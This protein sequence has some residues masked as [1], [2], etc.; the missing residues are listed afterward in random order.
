MKSA[1]AAL[2]ILLVVFGCSGEISK[3]APIPE[4]SGRTLRLEIYKLQDGKRKV[5][6]FDVTDPR[7]VDGILDV[8]RQGVGHPDHKCGRVGNAMI[9]FTDG[10]ELTVE[11]L[12]GHKLQNYEFRYQRQNYWVPREAFF[13]ALEKAGVDTRAV[14][15]SCDE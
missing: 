3:P 5:V 11:V 15:K 14:P 6:S 2:L 7:R 12:P 8:L 10:R 9:T 1:P 4:G 13:A